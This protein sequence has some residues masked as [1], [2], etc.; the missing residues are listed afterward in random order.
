MSYVFSIICVVLMCFVMLVGCVVVYM[1]KHPQDL[2]DPDFI[3]VFGKYY[4]GT[5][6][7]NRLEACFNLFMM[8]R[9]VIFLAV[10]FYLQT[11]SS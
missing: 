7:T 1:A 11:P 10:A 4:E 3:K 6:V 9:R 5:K 8:L 2:K